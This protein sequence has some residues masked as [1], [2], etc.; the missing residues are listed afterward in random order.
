[1]A[2]SQARMKLE[3]RIANLEAKV[4]QLQLTVGVAV[5]QENA[6]PWWES[7]VGAFAD[8]EAFIEAMR[9]GREY[10][11]S[12]RPKPT[13]QSKSAKSGNR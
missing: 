7:I 1:M 3:T 10:R 4:E 5:E 6:Q 13:K 11:E 12:L 2:T 9:F 8:D